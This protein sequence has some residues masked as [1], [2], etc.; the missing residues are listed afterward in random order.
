MHDALHLLGSCPQLLGPRIQQLAAAI[1]AACSQLQVQQ[2]AQLLPLLLHAPELLLPP[3]DAQ[4]AGSG[5]SAAADATASTLQALEG[6]L[7]GMQGAGS[8]QALLAYPQLLGWGE[9]DVRDALRELQGSWLCGGANPAAGGAAAVAGRCP[10][11]LLAAASGL[12]QRV[13]GLAAALAQALQAGGEGGG[14]RPPATAAGPLQQPPASTALVQQQLRQACVQA[15]W[16]LAVPAG[17]VVRAAECAS[18]ELGVTLA[19]AWPALAAQ[20]LV[21]QHASP[22]QQVQRLQ[23][24]LLVLSAALQLPYQQV[25]ARLLAGGMALLRFPAAQLAASHAQLRGLLQQPGRQPGPEGSGAGSSGRRRQPA[26][27]Q[28]GR[29][30]VP[31]EGAQPGNGQAP[32]A[33]C[34]LLRAHPL[35]LVPPLADAVVRDSGAAAAVSAGR[36]PD[37]VA[38]AMAAWASPDVS[39]TAAAAGGGLAG[40]EQAPAPQAAADR[41]AGYTLAS[42]SRVRRSR[43]V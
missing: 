18:R 31:G 36:L 15:P 16:L 37:G 26:D 1:S 4:A 13:E 2:P 20:P 5:A 35:L 3:E 30:Q 41:P 23:E 34:Q 25:K 27:P 22:T 33:A 9:A 14:R 7:P 28:P 39:G 42:G 29:Q 19:Q 43:R 12:E 6:T 24:Q 11:V 32:D 40:A 10:G 17:Q 8:G 21:L 38:A